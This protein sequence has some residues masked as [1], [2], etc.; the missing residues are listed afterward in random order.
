MSAFNTI[1]KYILLGAGLYVGVMLARH[2]FSEGMH[3]II[4]AQP[5][6]QVQDETFSPW[7]GCQLD[8]HLRY[9]NPARCQMEQRAYPRDSALVY[10]ADPSA[11]MTKAESEKASGW[12]LLTAFAIPFSLGIAAVL[13]YL[14]VRTAALRD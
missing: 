7:E 14:I 6:P 12:F 4:A 9:T 11:G 1:L 3:T 2:G 8:E 5:K 10:H 13:G